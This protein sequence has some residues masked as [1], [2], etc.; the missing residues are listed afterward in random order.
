VSLHVYALTAPQIGRMSLAG[1]A[2]ER[3]RAVE[4]GSIAAIVGEHSRTPRPTRD[5]VRRYD[6]VIRALARRTPALLPARFG[7]EVRGFDELALVLGSRQGSLRRQLTAV[8]RRVQ[9]T[10]RLPHSPVPRARPAGSPKTGSGYL[11]AR[12]RDAAAARDIPPFQPVRTAVR[13]WVREER[14]EQRGGIATIYHLIPRGSVDA[15][16]RALEVK[17]ERLGVRLMVSGPHPAYA[18]AGNW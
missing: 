6:Q 1:L 15:Y 8:R 3:L 18:F 4:V 10:I 14:V 11:R 2:G 12:A 5:N 13:R 9:M 16:R 17:A 7:T